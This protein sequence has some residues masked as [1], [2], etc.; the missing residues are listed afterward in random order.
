MITELRNST[1]IRPT[2]EI[3]PTTGDIGT[4]EDKDSMKY[5][6]KYLI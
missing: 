5:T 2:L 4:V 1:L 3:L 6:H